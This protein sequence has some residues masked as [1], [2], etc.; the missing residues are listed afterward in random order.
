M[1]LTFFSAE[2]WETWDV[3]RAPVIP[4]G[5][6]V[7]IDDDLI[8]EDGPGRPRPVLAVNRWLTELPVSGA[9]SPNS[10]AYYARV[11]KAWMEFVAGCGIDVFDSREALKAALG[12]YAGHRAAGPVKDRFVASTWNQHVSVLGV[13]YRWAISEGYASAEPFTYRGGLAVFAGTG[14]PVEVNLARRRMPRPHVSIS[15]PTA[16]GCSVP[17]SR[18]LTTR[19]CS[20]RGDWATSACRCPLSTPSPAPGCQLV[21][22]RQVTRAGRQVGEAA[23]FDERGQ[24]GRC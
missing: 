16:R 5:M 7:L 9:P 24:P 21:R 1:Q 13:F 19:A 23:G 18:R 22:F 6:P 3:D 4:A 14:R 2:G 20:R 15:F 11:I 17:L 8:F 12:K 10:W